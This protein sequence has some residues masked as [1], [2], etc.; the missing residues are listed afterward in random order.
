[1]KDQ[2][3]AERKKMTSQEIQVALIEQTKVIGEKSASVKAD[4]AGVEPAVMEAQQGTQNLSMHVG[5]YYV[6]TFYESN[7]Q[8]IY[9]VAVVVNFILCVYFLYKFKKRFTK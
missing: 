9:N 7:N 1:M 2:Q 5:F 3:E 4:L 6:H 8:Y